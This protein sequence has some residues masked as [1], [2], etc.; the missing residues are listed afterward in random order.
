M[1]KHIRVIFIIILM[2]F[3]LVGNTKKVY[4]TSKGYLIAKNTDE[5]IRDKEL[6]DKWKNN[7]MD[8]LDVFGEDAKYNKFSEGK[9]VATDKKEEREIMRKVVKERVS[10]AKF[11]GRDVNETNEMIKEV[12]KEVNFIRSFLVGFTVTTLVLMLVA[13]FV[14]LSVFQRSVFKRWKVLDDIKVILILA[15][16]LGILGTVVRL[17]VFYFIT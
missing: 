6:K 3:V 7:V 5:M 9:I 15:A 10:E 4:A 17:T 8:N 13:S 12:T 2:F 1:K 11:E 16:M 14:K